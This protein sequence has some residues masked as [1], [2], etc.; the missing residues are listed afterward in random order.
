MN[1]IALRDYASLDHRRA[2]RLDYSR[3]DFKFEGFS[4]ALA[5]S[6]R[7]RSTPCWSA[8]S[9]AGVLPAGGGV[10]LRA[11][12]CSGLW[13]PSHPV[14][15]G[16]VRVVEIDGFDARPAAARMP[17]TGELGSLR[18]LQDREQGQDQ[19]AA[20]RP[21]EQPLVSTRTAPHAPF[22]GRDAHHAGR[23]QLPV[24][25]RPGGAVATLKVVTGANGTGKSNVY[26]ALR[27][28]ADTAQ[29]G[30][31][32]SLAREGGLSS[33]C[34]PGRRA[35]AARSGAANTR[36]KARSASTRSACGSASPAT[37]SAM[38]STSACR[39]RPPRRSRSTR[40]SS[41]NASGAARCFA[42]PPC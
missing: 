22:R 11:P 19:Q 6:S 39:R 21:L 17:A 42:R 10:P 8:I 40:R 9:L 25:A 35:S 29:G 36:C 38:R 7:P 28:L 37:S 15:D 2:D 12:T 41:A 20:V 23:L 3:I 16:R 33:T 26:R 32:A 5:Q 24:V 31:I 27:L 34:G 1:T 18:D 4:P 30:V 14:I 13:R